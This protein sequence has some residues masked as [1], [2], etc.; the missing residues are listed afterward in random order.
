[1]LTQ[2][3]E[4]PTHYHRDNGKDDGKGGGGHTAVQDVESNEELLDS[5]RT[6]VLVVLGSYI[7]V[8]GVFIWF[9]GDGLFRWDEN[10]EGIGRLTWGGIQVVAGLLLIVVGLRRKVLTVPGVVSATGRT[11][12]A[13]V[14][15]PCMTS[16]SSIAYPETIS[17]VP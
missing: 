8:S 14:V 4:T 15:R 1:M 5:A 13:S 16:I 3:V 7:L 6:V 9:T 17:T 2:R 12:V 11:P 10:V